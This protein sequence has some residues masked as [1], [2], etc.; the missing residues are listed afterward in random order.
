MESTIMTEEELEQAKAEDRRRIDLYHIQQSKFR[1]HSMTI[2]K[3]GS[4]STEITLRGTD[5]SYLFNIYHP[6]EVIELIHQMAANIGC[7]INIK[8]RSDFATYREWREV[9]GEE[10]QHLNG[11]APFPMQ[12]NDSAAVG[13]GELSLDR[14]FS[15][16]NSD[17]NKLEAMKKDLSDKEEQLK[18]L[19]AEISEKE[20]HVATKKTINKR[21]IK[22]S[23]TATE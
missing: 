8:P 22:R 20:N 23:R 19:S 5:G 11:W 14:P 4:N 7:H 10:Q 21:S 18:M 17:I 9:S 1:A 13:S 6:A 3:C 15:V 2:G 12:S 16:Q